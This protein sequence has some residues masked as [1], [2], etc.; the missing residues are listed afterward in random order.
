MPLSVVYAITAALRPV[1]VGG[2][3]RER[4]ERIAILADLDFGILADIPDECDLV[5]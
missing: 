1:A 2:C 4:C 3:Q 5:D